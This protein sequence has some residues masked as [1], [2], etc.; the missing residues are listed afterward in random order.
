MAARAATDR[1]NVILVNCDDLGYG[2]LGCYG[3]ARNRTPVLDSLAAGGT[4]F[5]DFYMASPVC[6]PSRGGMLTGCYPRRIGFELFDNNATVLFPGHATGLSAGEVTIAALLSK[7][8]YATKIVGKWHCGDQPEFL[9]TRRGF[10]DYYGLPYSNDM[11]RQVGREHQ[12]PPLPL[13]SGQEV[14]EAQPDQASLTERYVEQC[15]RFIRA[16]RARPFFL[17]LAHMYVHLPIYVQEHFARQSANGRYGAAVACIDWSVGVLMHELR[18]LGI[19]DNTL[20]LFTSDNG[21]RN[22]DEGGSNAPLR[23]TKATCWEGG[24]RVPLIAYWPGVVPAGRVSAEIVASMDLLPT[25]AGLA[26]SSAPDDRPI[27]GRDIGNLLLGRTDRSGRE[28]FL[29]FRAGWLSAV[30]R[31]GWKLHVSREGTPVRELYNLREDVGET[32]NLVGAQ[33]GVIRE[34][35]GIIESVRDDIGDRLVGADG[36]NC[37][38]PGKAADPRPLTDFD[39]SCPY[40][41]AE[42]DLPDAG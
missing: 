7:Q 5:T 30:R 27:D 3:S 21:S 9:P 8:G 32:T 11:G 17:Y 33:P 41:M 2:D 31:G 38:P 34:I 24:Q 16:N 35:E 26:G 19:A 13:I 29:Y 12:M 14:V 1:P 6:S 18:R 39:P 28:T 20:V 42:Y 40:Y 22:R 10:D 25:L 4:R 36:A 15:V 23:G 37:R